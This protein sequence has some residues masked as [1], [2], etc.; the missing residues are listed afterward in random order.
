MPLGGT[1]TPERTKTSLCGVDSQLRE[2]PKM[3]IR[4][5]GKIER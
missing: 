3:E 2:K 1:V 5:C 4:L